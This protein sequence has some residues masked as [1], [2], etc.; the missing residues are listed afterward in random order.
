MNN[1]AIR[2]SRSYSDVSGIISLWSHRSQTVIVYQHEK[3]EEVNRTHIHMLL[4][5]VDCQ[6]E[7]LKRLAHKIDSNLSGNKDWSFKDTKLNLDNSPDVEGYITYMT[8]GKYAASF[9][10]NY[11]PGKLEEARLKWV[12]TKSPLPSPPPPAETNHVKSRVTHM[13]L[14][15]SM[16]ADYYNVKKAKG[17]CPSESQVVEL[18]VKVLHANRMK[19]HPKVVSE[20][21]AMI[22]YDDFDMRESYYRAVQKYFRWD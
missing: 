7:R 5:G 13:D 1:Y 2:V 10:K 11:S 4:M 18:I 3:D 22:A 8:K 20:F 17:S 6:E 14:F 9:V 15:A 12:E 21:M 19:S 16:L